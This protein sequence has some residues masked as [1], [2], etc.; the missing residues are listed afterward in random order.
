[1]QI[2]PNEFEKRFVTH[3]MKNGKKSIQPNPIHSDI[4]IRANPNEPEPIRNQ[5]FN[6]NQSE[7]GLI[8]TEFS[9]RIN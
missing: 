4:Y 1:M 7:L 5:V 9:I 2:I 3:L 8:Q 6:P